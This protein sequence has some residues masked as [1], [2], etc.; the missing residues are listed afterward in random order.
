[1]PLKFVLDTLDALPLATRD[2]YTKKEDGKYH[3]VVDG[4]HPDT[5]KVK[6]MRTNNIDLIRERDDLKGALAADR[7]KLAAFE[8][9]NPTERITELEAQLA[10]EKGARVTAQQKADRSL[11]RDAL[12][13]KLLSTGVLPAALDIALDKIESAFETKDDVVVARPDHFSKAKP[14]EPL[15]PDE[16]ILGAIKEHSYLF[17]ASSGGGA[18]PSSSLFGHA[19]NQKVLKDPTPQQLGDPA[20]AAALKSGKLKVEYST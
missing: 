13:T 5:A 2:L 15:T 4:D 11:L 12:R 19:S 17:K 20:T 18:S 9:A 10:A 6:E 14:G 16:W 8:K 7:A 3:L 1:M